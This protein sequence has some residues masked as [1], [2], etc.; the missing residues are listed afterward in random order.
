[1]MRF[2]ALMFFSISLLPALRAQ[3][4]QVSIQPEVERLMER[5]LFINR[6]TPEL[7]GYRVQILATTDRRKM[8][9][10]RTSF[11]NY[12][13]QDI[14]LDWIHEKPWYKLRAGAFLSRL[15]AQYMLY[16]LKEKYPG[17]YLTNAKNINPTEVLSLR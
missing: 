14:P 10:E 13:G 17:A 3:E 12:Y 9:N 5:N 15:D 6:N 2:I 4:I 16:Q 8:E 11:R 7:E 1:M